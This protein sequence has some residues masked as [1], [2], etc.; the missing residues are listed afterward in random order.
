MKN[1]IQQPMSHEQWDPTKGDF[2]SRNI[3]EEDKSYEKKQK[4]KKA[5]ITFLAVAHIM[6]LFA[7]FMFY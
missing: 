1:Y 2:Y 7:I 6:L 5:L 4:K 3:H